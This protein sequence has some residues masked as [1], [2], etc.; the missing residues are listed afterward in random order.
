[1]SP[2][3]YHCSTPQYNGHK[4]TFCLS[5]LKKLKKY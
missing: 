4:D 1:M 5:I 2:T 3:S